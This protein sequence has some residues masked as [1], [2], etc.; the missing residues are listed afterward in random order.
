MDLHTRFERLGGSIE[1]APVDVIEADLTRGRRA[2]RRRRTFQAV[3]G[4]VAGIAAIAVAVSFTG[5]NAGGG[6]DIGRPPVVAESA[7]GGLKLVD[8]RGT[9]PKYFTVDKV[10]A[11]Y[12]IQNDNEGGLTIAP[13]SAKNPG[14]GVDPSK[15]PMYDPNDLGGKIGI[16][17]EQ[18]SYRGNEDGEKVTV[19]GHPTIVHHIGPT[20]QLLISVSS[21]VYATVQFDVALTM[22][23]ML[24][25]GAGLHVAQEAIDRAAAATG[26]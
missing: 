9:Q 4:S 20:T 16:Y 3:A 1:P 11:G 25:V 12:F 8:Y 18:K 2:V 26:K 10:P 19:A 5:G 14:P 23:Q 21:D 15:A 7:T 24:E 6:S 13:D 22:D 17:L